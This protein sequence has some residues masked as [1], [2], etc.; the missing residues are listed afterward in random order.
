MKDIQIKNCRKKRM[1]KAEIKQA[2][3]MLKL[4]YTI[5]STVPGVPCIYYG[6]EAGMEGHRDP[7]NRMPYPWG[8][9]NKSLV[10][11]YQKVGKIR[12]NE[13]IFKDGFFKIIRCDS[14]V[15]A[16]ARYN[17]K[18]FALT[19]VNRSEH[20]YRLDSNVDLFSYE[21]G[22]KISVFKPNSA[23]VLKGKAD[24]LSSKIEFYK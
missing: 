10:E 8:K 2:V 18:G 13:P 23:C 19:V 3:S 4:A 7:F 1:P 14:D 11:F 9:E 6:D 5:I 24:F 12:R 21:S 22:R 17:E 15:L 20:T 16:F